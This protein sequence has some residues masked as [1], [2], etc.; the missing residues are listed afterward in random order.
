M[1]GSTIG[2]LLRL[3]TFG[4]SHGIAVGCILDGCP[5]GLPLSEEDIQV[6]LDKRKPGEGIAGTARKE[7]DT[8]HILSGVFDGVTTG[9]PIA[10]ITH[11]ENQKS[12][13]YDAI[14]DMFRP[15][16]A[17]YTYHMKFDG[18]RDYR[19]G[20]R[21]SARETLA[22]VAAGAIAKKILAREGI[23]IHGYVKSI[24]TIEAKTF[25]QKD[26]EAVYSNELRCPDAAARKK[27]EA[28]I[29]KARTNKDSLGGVIEVIAKG[30]PAGL[31][32]PVF[33]KLNAEIAKSLMSIN[34]VKGVEIGEG[35]AA[36]RMMGSEHNDAIRA[37][38][39][40]AH[41][42]TNHAGGILGGIS[43]GSDIVARVA[44]KP[45][46][47]IAQTQKTITKDFKNTD[48]TVI[49]RHDVCV[50]PRAVPIV[51]AMLALTLAD[52]L[53]QHKARK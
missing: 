4:E 52:A 37:K 50:L 7:S 16:H 20:G 41:F 6:E 11:N 19:G 39:G 14:K 46:A 15:G 28:L 31:G 8:I 42:V 35:F 45:V 51:E 3:T 24:H 33:S 43:D 27:M 9:T 2:T 40:I 17:D 30:V 53:L 44:I 38:E 1:T 12:E 26:I 23:H 10:L 47:S 5:A 22:R 13:H 25:T 32:E 48:I 29:Q 49:G 18:I 34:A 36:T 21:S